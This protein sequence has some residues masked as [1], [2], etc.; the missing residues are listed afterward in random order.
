V[1]AHATEYRKGLNKI[2][3]ILGEGKVVEFVDE[4]KTETDEG[5]LTVGLSCL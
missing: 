4:L 5:Q 2:F 3:V 1:N